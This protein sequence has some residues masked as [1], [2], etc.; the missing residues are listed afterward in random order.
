MIE[1]PEGMRATRAL[2]SALLTRYSRIAR[3][4]ARTTHTNLSISLGSPAKA[5][6]FVSVGDPTLPTTKKQGWWGLQLGQWWASGSNR[7]VGVCG[8]QVQEN[9]LSEEGETESSR[10]VVGWRKKEKKKEKTTFPPVV[11]APLSVRTR[12]PALMQWD[13]A[14]DDAGASA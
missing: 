9:K 8:E 1:L 3:A 13:R 11:L 4:V 10:N 5:H 2:P 14:H 6:H 12:G 7:D